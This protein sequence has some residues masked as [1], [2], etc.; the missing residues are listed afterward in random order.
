MFGFSYFK[1]VSIWK[2][3]GIIT[4]GLVNMFSFH[5]IQFRNITRFM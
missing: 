2:L 3:V 4:N 1:Y 5:T